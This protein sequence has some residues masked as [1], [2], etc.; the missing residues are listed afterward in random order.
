MSAAAAIPPSG[1][2]DDMRTELANIQ[3]QQNKVTD[4]VSMLYIYFKTVSLIFSYAQR[5]K[6][7]VF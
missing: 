2:E 5:R 1:S 3:F 4:D 6:R 7:A